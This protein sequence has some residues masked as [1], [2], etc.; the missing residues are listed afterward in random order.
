VLNYAHPT[1]T[2]DD[3]ARIFAL[4]RANVYP[5]VDA[6][7]QRCGHAI[8]RDRLEDA[9]RVLSCPLKAVPPNWQHGRVIFA[10]TRRY[11]M[12]AVIERPF[13]FLDIGTAKGFSALCL[14]WG[15]APA[16][17]AEV[18][19]VDVMPP[20]ARVRR[21]TPAEVAGLRTLAEILQPWPEAR[22]IQFEESTGIDWLTKHP[23]RVH[24]AFVDGKH[25]GVVVKQEGK[26]LAARQ[27][28]GDLVIVDDIQV[29]SVGQA[30][31]KLKDY[32]VEYLEVKP[33]R[34]Y[35]IAVRR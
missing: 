4:E 25:D 29:P 9:A 17:A 11:T 31:A 24:V 23:E 26:L 20:D 33:G 10:A 30:V 21:N 8:D 6:F 12:D 1:V 5:M 15:L 2:A 28:P 34:T 3:Y 18:F 19:S 32:A 35:G 14:A 27:E 7:E 13:R 16:W 22:Y